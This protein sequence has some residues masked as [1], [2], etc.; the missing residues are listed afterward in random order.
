[1]IEKV[2][3]VHLYLSQVMGMV[4]LQHLKSQGVAVV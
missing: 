4:V 3:D 1:M 2:S